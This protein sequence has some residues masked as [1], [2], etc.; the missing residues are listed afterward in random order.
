M[1]TEIPDSVDKVD[2]PTDK[3]VAVELESEPEG[4]NEA[5][6]S[7]SKMTTKSKKSKTKIKTIPFKVTRKGT[8][9]DF[10]VQK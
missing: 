7:K 10:K 6:K 8:P 9:Q 4:N 1:Q 3:A 5:P 2:S